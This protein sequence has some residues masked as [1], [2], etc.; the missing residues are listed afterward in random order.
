MQAGFSLQLTITSS[1]RPWAL[2]EPG[3]QAWSQPGQKLHPEQ[4]PE[5]VPERAR[6]QERA[7]GQAPGPERVRVSHRKR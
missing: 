7:R 4:A 6:E 3:L 1:R 2:P 5:R